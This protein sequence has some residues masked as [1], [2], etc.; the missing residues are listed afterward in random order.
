MGKV[1]SGLHSWRGAINLDLFFVLDCHLWT[2][3]VDGP[4]VLME[5]V[6]GEH[7]HHNQQ[8]KDTEEDRRLVYNF[9]FTITTTIRCYQC[10]D[11]ERN[12]KS[13][14]TG[15]KSIYEEV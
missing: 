2:G 9:T 8:K 14:R 4:S 7:E 5:G 13:M 3:S 15:D 6:R 10:K 1:Q 12:G 11:V